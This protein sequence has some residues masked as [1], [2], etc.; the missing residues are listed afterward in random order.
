MENMDSRLSDFSI[1]GELGTGSSG[2]VYKAKSL[3]DNNIYAL[4]KINISNLSFEEKSEA[5]TLKKLDHPNIIKYYGSFKEGDWFYIIMEYA[6][7]GDLH[8][9]FKHHQTLKVNFDEKEIW[10]III[11]LVKGISYLH[12]QHIIHRDIKCLNILLTKDRKP[13]LGDLGSSKL[14]SS[15]MN[16]NRVG[17]PHYLSP[18]MV[19]CLPYDYKTD[20]WAL[21]CV[22]YTLACL[23]IPFK[24]ESLL[25]L[26][27]SIVNSEP[28]RLPGMYSQDLTNLCMKLLMK[29]PVDRPTAEEIMELIPSQYKNEHETFINIEEEIGKQ[30]KTDYF[31]KPNISPIR[32]FSLQ[33]KPDFSEKYLNKQEI[34]NSPATDSPLIGKVLVSLERK[35]NSKRLLIK[36]ASVGQNK[37]AKLI[38]LAN[39]RR[40][41]ESARRPLTSARVLYQTVN[42][43]L[44]PKDRS[45]S[46]LKAPHLTKHEAHP[47]A[48]STKMPSLDGDDEHVGLKSLAMSR[49]KSLS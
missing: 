45:A 15:T 37:K 8:K 18:E 14:V 24:G 27:L 13:K 7:G 28:K 36:R 48:F 26:G 32:T 47:L 9:L 4:K 40:E 31:R 20:I 12:S 11:G 19:R 42:D 21:G 35:R 41:P 44:T 38:S 17:T 34:K 5:Q 6:E 3:I 2:T 22:V 29:Q 25:S 49:T 43:S 39:Q 1:Q 16:Y 23:E 30:Y 46:A 10:K 33:E